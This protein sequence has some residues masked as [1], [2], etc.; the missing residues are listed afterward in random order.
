MEH[1]ISAVIQMWYHDH[2]LP[3]TCRNLANSIPKR[4]PMVIKNNGGHVKY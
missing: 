2:E 4:F 3:N 1:L